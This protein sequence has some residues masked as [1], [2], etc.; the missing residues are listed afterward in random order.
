MPFSVKAL[1]SLIPD[2]NPSPGPCS[3]IP[4][5]DPGSSLWST[6]LDIGP[7]SSPG[8]VLPR[9]NDEVG[10]SCPGVAEGCH[11]GLIGCGSRP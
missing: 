2:P 3:L 9:R 4:D 5:P 7:G 6:G 11:E 10:F 8:Q 1:A